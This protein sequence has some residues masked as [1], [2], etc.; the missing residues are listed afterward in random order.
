MINE[1]QKQAAL[2]ILTGKQEK[3]DAE[4]KKKLKDESLH[5]RFEYER[6]VLRCG[7]SNGYEMI[8]PSPMSEE[9]NVKYEMFLKKANDIWDEFTTGN[10][11]QK[12]KK[13][14][15][16]AKPEIPEAKKALPRKSWPIKKEE[17]PGANQNQL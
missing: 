5:Q 7:S 1:K 2:R 6:Q 13:V 9:L 10:K 16:H 12:H 15:E 8:H 11:G 3:I 4:T 17:K 14:V